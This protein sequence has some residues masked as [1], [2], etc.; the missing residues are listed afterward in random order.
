VQSAPTTTSWWFQPRGAAILILVFASA[1]PSRTTEQQLVNPQRTAH[2]GWPS[3]LPGTPVE[4]ESAPSPIAWTASIPAAPIV[5]P[6]TTADRVIVAHLP[7]VVTAFDRADKRELWRANLS[8]EQPLVSD[9]AL[10]FVQ[11]EGA[12]HALR[13]ED[14]VTAWRTPTGALTAPL[15][16]KEGWLLAATAGK[17][18][19]LRAQEGT[20]VWTVDAPAQHEMA[21]IAGNVVYTPVEGGRLIARDL[22]DGREKWNI[23]LGGDATE[24]LVIGGDVFVG[25]ADKRFYCLDA[26]SGRIEWRTRVGA[27]I[28]G[29]AA[30]DVD[31]VFF[32][33][34]DNQVH[35]LDRVTGELKWAK[36]VPFRP[37]SGPIVAAGAV[38]VVGSE[39]RIFR[40]SDGTPAG[41]VAL[42]GRPAIAPGHFETDAGAVFAVVTGTLDESWN[43]SL[44][45]PL[46]ATLRPRR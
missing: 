5:S 42:P 37:M 23:Q 44:T 45:V 40:A 26:A 27:L 17:L 3:P 32:T 2:P 18:T 8:P 35:A 20:A 14:G 46:P 33:A 12:I 29:R 9:G 21:A 22:A 39:L 41:T 7:G 19:A 6:L 24:P 13:L 16:A 36:G 25:A 31:R 43:L 30:G 15:V 34:L 10:L 11:A 38:F 1:V 28:R 4:I